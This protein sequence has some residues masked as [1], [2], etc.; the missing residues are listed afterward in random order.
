MF[1]GA[2]Q[3]FSVLRLLTPPFLGKLVALVYSE[4]KTGWRII[5]LR[6]ATEKEGRIWL[7]K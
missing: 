6:L 7:G 5:N 4:T 3:S 2:L 1:C